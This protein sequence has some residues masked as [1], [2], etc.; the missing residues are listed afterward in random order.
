MNQPAETS[1]VMRLW[2]EL[3]RRRVVRV[4]IVYMVVGWVVIEVAS[5]MLPGLKLPEWSVTLVIALV[6][7]G[8]PIAVIMGWVFDIGPGG[9]ARTVAES[10]AAV[11]AVHQDPA[12]AHAPPDVA[13]ESE[14]SAGAPDPQETQKDSRRSIA[15]L[16]FV[17]MS[18]QA[19][20]EYFSDGRWCMGRCRIL[21]HRRHRCFGFG[22]GTRHATRTDVEDPAHD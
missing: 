22:D 16:P 4:V 10:E 17:N 19:D 8:F 14:H 20:N 5:T 9:M 2:K 15:V 11:P 12:S 13:D 7:L 6:V 3:R 18:G 1:A 21:V